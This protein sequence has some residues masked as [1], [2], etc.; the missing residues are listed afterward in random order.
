MLGLSAPFLIAN[1]I[2]L[3]IALPAHEFAHAFSANAFGDNTPRQYGRLTLNPLAHLDVLGSLMMVFAG[4]G[5]AK[6]VP[7]SPAALNRRSSSA[8]MWVSLAGPLSNLLLAILAA[9][10][11]RLHLVPYA[12]NGDVLPSLY[13]LLQ[14]FIWTN[15]A[16]AVFNLIPLAPLDGEK[17]MDYFA[18]PSMARFMDTIRP[19]SSFILL[20]MVLVLPRL[21]INIIGWIINPAISTLWY[22]II[23]G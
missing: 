3:F 17:I 21:G 19:Y 1:L 2:S 6:P 8:L 16:L 15:L 12:A 14:Y 11:F 9:I 23:G 4:F 20:A 22:L 13:M 5:W 7:V 18:P 10:P